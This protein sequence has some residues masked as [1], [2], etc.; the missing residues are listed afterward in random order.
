[1]DHRSDLFAAGVVLYETLTRRRLYDAPTAVALRALL[2]QP[3]VPPSALNPAVPRALDDLCARALE[4]DPE[5]RLQTGT[6]L[7]DALDEVLWQ[8]RWHS[9]RLAEIVR[10]QLPAPAPSIDG[11]PTPAANGSID[12]A[13]RAGAL[14][15]T[16][17]PSPRSL[18]TPITLAAL[19]TLALAV[20]AWTMHRRTPDRAVA[21]APTVAV[22]IDS[23]PPNAELTLDGDPPLHAQTPFA[24]RVPQT[25]RTR[26]LRLRLAGYAPVDL[27]LRPRADV[28]L[29][30]PLPPLAAKN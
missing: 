11:T 30:V 3:F 20:V 25:N 4:R 13:G 19:L 6:Q 29:D 23:Q 14:A 10:R 27:V 17:S 7:A 1:F 5:R 15:A 16:K 18:R 12:R 26:S 21:T 22:R 28:V 8:L 9:G 2:A 24:G